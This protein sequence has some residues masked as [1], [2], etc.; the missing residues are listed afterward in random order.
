MVS[1]PV[2]SNAGPS[3]LHPQSLRRPSAQTSRSRKAA[4]G[5]GDRGCK[6]PGYWF[7]GAT[8]DRGWSTA[9]RETWLET[10]HRNGDLPRLKR[11]S[12]AHHESDPLRPDERYAETQANR[13]TSAALHWDC[14]MV[15]PSAQS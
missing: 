8:R 2:A 3:R 9:L 10:D 12:R 5:D 4:D 6:A 7:H 11:G 15:A 13:K 14:G 1:A